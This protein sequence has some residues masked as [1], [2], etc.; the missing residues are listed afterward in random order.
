MTS[1]RSV[2]QLNEGC[3]WH[4]SHAQS[5]ERR[6]IRRAVSHLQRFACDTAV[7]AEKRDADAASINVFSHQTRESL[8]QLQETI[9][10]VQAGAEHRT[11][12][13]KKA[14]REDVMTQARA[15]EQFA[16]IK[17]LHPSTID[18]SR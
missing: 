18:F 13:I 10:A 15:L 4:R 7:W 9:Q 11:E 1:G 6:V 3:T 2:N 12:E 5:R 8:G 17:L 14:V 16:I